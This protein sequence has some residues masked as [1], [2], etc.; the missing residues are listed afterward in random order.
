MTATRVSELTEL[1]AYRRERLDLARALGH[2]DHVARCAER[3]EALEIKLA[4]VKA[5]AGR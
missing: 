3:V 2:P 5:R 1:L 4:A